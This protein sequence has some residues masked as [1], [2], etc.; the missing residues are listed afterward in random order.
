MLL[1]FQS[2]SLISVWYADVYKKMI[3]WCWL[4]VKFVMPTTKSRFISL[5]IVSCIDTREFKS[6][7]LIITKFILSIHKVTADTNMKK[8]PWKIGYCAK[9][10]TIWCLVWDLLAFVWKDGYSVVDP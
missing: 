2:V 6:N 4:L 3:Y 7:A 10:R 1:D 5:D 8:M 9:Q